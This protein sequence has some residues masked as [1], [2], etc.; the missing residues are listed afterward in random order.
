M[1]TLRILNQA[2]SK[3]EA[4]VDHIDLTIERLE[5]A[6][7]FEQADS[8][9]VTALYELRYAVDGLLRQ[10]YSERLALEGPQDCD[11]EVVA[12]PPLN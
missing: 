7:L 6:E 12:P 8:S 5:V 3:L 1:K 10:H 2:I 11:F 4:D 9:D